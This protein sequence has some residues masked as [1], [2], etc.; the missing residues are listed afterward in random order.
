MK[1]CL[2]AGGLEPERTRPAT[3]VA[4]APRAPPAAGA[5]HAVPRPPRQ[6]QARYVG[7][8]LCLCECVHVCAGRGGDKGKGRGLGGVGVGTPI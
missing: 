6:L 7:A 5:Q 3:A 2:V 4:R 1:V 8:D